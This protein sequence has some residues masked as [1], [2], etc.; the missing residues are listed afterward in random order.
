MKQILWLILKLAS[1]WAMPA[2]HA[3][4]IRLS[5]E[6][7][8]HF[9]AAL[10]AHTTPQ[11]DV[12]RIRIVLLAHQK[13]TNLQIAE[14]L[15]CDVTTVAKWRGRFA[16]HGRAGLADQPRSG[17]PPRFSPLEQAQV[18]SLLCQPHEDQPALPQD[19]DLPA[20]PPGPCVAAPSVGS[21][22]AAL[23]GPADLAAVAAGT[24]QAA[25]AGPPEVAAAVS[26]PQEVAFAAL[27]FA[28]IACGESQ[29]AT[30]AQVPEVVAPSVGPQEA[31]FA[32]LPDVAAA[33]AVAPDAV[34]SAASTSPETEPPSDPKGTGKKRR[35]KQVK[36][37]GKKGKKVRPEHERFART[38]PVW[39]FDPS[40]LAKPTRVEVS[41]VSPAQTTNQGAAFPSVVWI[42]PASVA[43]RLAEALE[44]APQGRIAT[45]DVPFVPATAVD[46]ARLAAG[47]E[48]AALP[49][50]TA[51][52]GVCDALGA[53]VAMVMGPERTAMAY[54]GMSLPAVAMQI[55]EARA[56]ASTASVKR[57]LGCVLSLQQILQRMEAEL[58]LNCSRSTL[59]RMLAR[60][61]LKPWR[62]Q[63]WIFP[64]GANFA[65]RAG[66]ILD[67]Y[68]GFWQGQEL[69]ADE[70]VLSLDEKTSIQ[71][72]WRC[73]ETLAGKAGRATRV[74][75]GYGR[76]GA[77]QYLA[78][79]DVHRGKVFGQCSKRVG[80]EAFDAMLDEVMKQE[81]YKSA[82]RVF[83]IVDNGS[84][85]RGQ[86]CVER[87]EGR[88]DNLKVVHTPVHASWVNQIEI[89]FSVIQRALLT[90]ND[91]HDLTHLEK[92][93][94]AFQR[95][96]NEEATPFAWRFTRA[97]L[98]GLLKKLE[99]HKRLAS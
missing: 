51:S 54:L 60:H 86:K 5:I 83:A 87:L 70:Y 74:E 11:R 35:N 29:Q 55:V 4:P 93:I 45:L 20:P 13:F 94:M 57:P 73:H 18:V 90:P 99:A 58:H 62:Y 40:L 75:W 47:I 1:T 71:A 49:L 92:A 37:P 33:A 38:Q 43:T 15:G 16:S 2:P 72:R 31:A 80:I 46:L 8:I 65:E 97:K 56:M 6:D 98:A 7:L 61:A 59:S 32:P 64:T 53:S 52:G 14:I 41:I 82:R 44:L 76:G 3:I 48:P 30:L 84:S 34:G 85:H 27:P 50:L 66:R 68:A 63:Y 26:G 22:Q 23:A 21:G 96:Y 81:P 91:F 19:S 67:L 89:Y 69:A 79:W 78:C 39:Q 25:L 77:L 17:R 42:D 24:Q 36:R 9:D 28:A 12:L 95:S 10:K 88:Y